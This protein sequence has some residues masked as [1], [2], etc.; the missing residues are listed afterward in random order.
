MFL[1]GISVSA[2]PF[3]QVAVIRMVCIGSLGFFWNFFSA[4]ERG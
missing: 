3:G 1:T 4:S 2:D